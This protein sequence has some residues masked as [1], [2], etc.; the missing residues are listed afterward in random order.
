MKK[1]RMK[2]VIQTK[3][4]DQS[5]SSNLDVTNTKK[6]NIFEFLFFNLYSKKERIISSEKDC[7]V[8]TAT[9]KNSFVGFQ[10]LLTS[11][12]LT[13]AI[14]FAVI[15]LGMT[16][17]Q[18][19]WCSKIKGLIIIKPDESTFIYN[20]E[21]SFWQTWNKP[22]YFKCSPFTKTIWIDSDC[23]VKKDL[24]KIINIVKERPFFSPDRIASCTQKL[25]QLLTIKNTQKE[26]VPYLNAGVIG[27][28][29]SR[30]QDRTILETWEKTIL[31]SLKNKELR[32]NLIFHDQSA[33]K[34][35]LDKLNLKHLISKDMFINYLFNQHKVSLPIPFIKNSIFLPGVINHF[36]AGAVKPWYQWGEII[37]IDFS[38]FELDFS[39]PQ[40]L[41]LNDTDNNSCNDSNLLN[42]DFSDIV[43]KNKNISNKLIFFV[44]HNDQ[45]MLDSIKNRSYIK[46]INLN[47]LDIN[48][49]FKTNK[50][51]ENRFYLSNIYETHH[52]YVGFGSAKWNI[53]YPNNIKIEDLHMIE[54]QLNPKT[55][56]IAQR[57]YAGWDEFSDKWHPGI[58]KLIHEL[59]EVSNLS[60]EGES[61]WANNYICHRS[62]FIKFWRP[63]FDYFYNKY[64]LDFPFDVGDF[65]KRHVKPAYLLERITTIY[66][67]NRKDLT[68]T[69]LDD[70]LLFS[71]KFL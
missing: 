52:E 24:N 15:D 19:R 22:L 50:L 67:S 70:K 9:D 36:V 71:C 60:L 1:N 35:T 8:I 6:I 66:F 38:K 5:L 16:E 41:F 65:N 55:V 53:K 37:D 28:D 47:T 11:C 13:H 34:W 31:L 29:L 18:L 58:I 25:Y 32:K 3:I 26:T 39:N 7:G 54:N 27:L 23:M 2:I 69:P 21:Q 33:L 42:H 43:L 63:M 51:C 68:L 20:K 49:E 48:S 10:L 4:K 57:A 30:E 14:N 40:T 17:H 46:K 45:K 56:F 61:L 64:G 12:F 62:V 44:L 59:S